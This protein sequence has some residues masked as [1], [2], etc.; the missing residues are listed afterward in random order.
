MHPP[1]QALSAL[2]F[3]S[4]SLPPP[5]LSSKSIPT[6]KIPTF[7]F[8]KLPLA[9]PKF[10]L[11]VLH[12]T[13]KPTQQEQ[14]ILQFVADS[15]DNTLPCVRTFENDLARLSLVGSVRF[16]QALTAAAADGG[17]AASEH[18]ESGVPAM[19][20]ETI[21]PGPADEHATVSTRLFLPAK[22]VKEK[23]IRLKR[24]FKKDVLSDTTSQNIL[25]MTFRQVVLQQI[26]NFELVVFRPGTERNMK[27]LDNP[28]EEVPAS[29]FLGSSDEQVISLLAEAL[30]IAAL[31]NTERLFLDDFMGNGSGGFFS[32]LRKPQ[33]IASR[34]S[35]VVIYKLFED[36]IVENAKSLL[37]NFN[38]SKE[39]FQGIKVKRKYRWWTPLA[40]SK[41]E[42]IGGPEF[43]A[44]TSE[45]VPAYRLQID[46]DK[47]KDAKFEGWR[48]SSGNR[49]EVLLT[50]SQMVGLAEI[51]DMYYEDIYTMP[52]KELSCGV[53]SNFT[54]LS[55]KKR[56]SYLMNVLSVTLVSGIFLISISALSQFSLPHLRKGRMHA[57]EN[58]F[59]PSS[60]IQFAANEPL[61]AAKLQEFCI[62]I[63]KK[64]K[65]SFGW[66]GDIVTDQKIGAWI[67]EIP[68]YFK[69]MDEVDAASEENSNDSTPIQNIDTDLKSSAQD[70]ASYQ[71]VLST[72]GKI[73]GFQ[74]TSGVGVNH[75]AANPLAKE[76]YGGRNL[77]P[78]FIEPGLK[79][80]FPNEVI[81]IELLVSVNSDAYFALARPV[82]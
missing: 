2:S 58:S 42:K 67:G 66:P 76:L 7:F 38:S 16:D 51:F 65:D 10:P 32:W 3:P 43:S 64:M 13:P 4:L 78:G 36:E 33:R 41:L 79:I 48:E 35:S 26:W 29:F 52:N 12:C 53:V 68:T 60:E 6:T 50:H 31:Q 56:S 49:R 17:R 62:L 27:D 37:E 82:R 71:V 63:C 74:P 54:N 80:H 1:P 40:H 20:V 44:W 19:V 22:K 5:S 45:H 30:C 34:D 57:Q 59:L 75:W 25:S 24:S 18:L 21:F 8:P 77:S 9:I 15:K 61:D 39:R 72:D 55:K 28:R 23:A 46:A 47:V 81:L 69:M 14:Q 11:H 70:I 73:V